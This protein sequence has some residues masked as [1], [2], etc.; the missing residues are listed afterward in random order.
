LVFGPGAGT[1]GLFREGGKPARSVAIPPTNETFTDIPT[2][3]EI[4][5]RHGQDF[6]GPPLPPK[7]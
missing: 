3:M 2:L 4:A 1:E 6:V 7:D 5:Q